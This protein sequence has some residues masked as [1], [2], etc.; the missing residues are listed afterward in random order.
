MTYVLSTYHFSLKWGGKGI[1]TDDAPAPAVLTG[2]TKGKHREIINKHRE[3]A[4]PSSGPPG[5]CSYDLLSYRAF[6]PWYHALVSRSGIM[7]W[8]HDN[9]VL[10]FILSFS[11]PLPLIL[12]PAAK[13]F[14]CPR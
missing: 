3:I 6:M 1:R 14:S 13:D 5:V 12:I 11:I 2:R 4:A 9:P 8:F 10:R 7:L